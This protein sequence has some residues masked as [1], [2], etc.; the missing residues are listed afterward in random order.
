M[1]NRLAREASPY[2]LQHADNPVDWYPWG[3]EA[4]Q[5]SRTLDR[6]ILLSIGY[7][8][9][10]WCHV[11]ERE[12]FENED[13]ARLMNEL[14][15]CVKVDREERPDLDQVYQLVVQLMGRSGGWPL[16]VFLTPDQ[17]PFFGGTYFPPVDRYGMPGFPRVLQAIAEA[18]R[19]RR[20]EVDEQSAELTK[21]IVEVTT[22]EARKTSG[23]SGA[24]GEHG[25]GPDLVARAV[26]KLASRF[27]DRHGGFG[28]KPK[29]PNT[30]SLDL[31]SR[32]GQGDRVVKALDAMRAGG[33]WDHLGGGFHR[34]STDERWLV[35]HFEKMLYDNALL[36]RAYTDGW[37]ATRD[38]RHAQTVR[39]IAGYLA[40]EMTAPGG[41]FYATQ[42]ADSEGEEGRFFVWT[43]AQVDEALAS[44]PEAARVAKRVWGIEA[45]GNFE[46][47]G[48]TVLSQVQAPADAEKAALERARRG[49]FDARELRPRPF[50]D[51]KIL[52]SWNGL[53]IGALADAGVALDEP[54]LLQ[55]AERAM[56]YLQEHLLSRDVHGHARVTRLAKD[57]TAKGQGFLDDHAYVADA[58]LDLYEAT[59]QAR[60]VT[61]ARSLADAILAH[62]HDAE[63]Q[64]FFFTPDDGESLLVRAKDPHDHAVP[65]G[66]S[67]ASRVLLRLGTLVDEAYESPAARAVEL[68]APAAADNPGAMSGTVCLADRLVRGS[69]DVVVVGP[70]A[71]DATRALV[72]EAFR[73][74]LHDRVV[75]WVD[76]SDP[77][78]L[79][80]CAAIGRDKP[81]RDRPVAYVCRGRT[82]SAPVSDPGELAERLKG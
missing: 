28:Q 68:L 5:V 31:L 66:A 74:P 30:M 80:A 51:E 50:R 78:S 46:P 57:G 49:L 63:G 55:A 25:L 39:A 21:A 19:D 76:P 58:A 53:A 9:C 6:P 54:A 79:A 77:E 3:P 47:S 40:R 18:Y 7:S 42:D 36:L 81:A 82:C 67:I 35:P 37:R 41:A 38:E 61:L 73:A 44:D 22:G 27:D 13:T 60:Y 45:H 59:G 12:S 8:A 34:Y 62:F 2:L 43:P 56:A 11:M 17:K 20:G 72:R 15:V 26:Q 75:A 64:G 29:F 24:S 32:G 23:A 71:S 65:S 69:V 70:R 52:A 1:P 10:H 4:L 33:I 48:A 14:F 16:T